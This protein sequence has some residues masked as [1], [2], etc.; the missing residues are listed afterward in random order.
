MRITEVTKEEIFKLLDTSEAGLKDEE[1]QRRLLY[2]G[3]N[4]IKEIRKTS[5]VLKFLRQFTHFLA[6]ILWLASALAFISDYIHPG[7]GMRHLGFAIIGVICINA[8]FAFVQEYKAEKAIEKLRQMLPFY[9]KVIRNGI[10]KEIPAREIVPGDLIIL[11]EGDKIPADARVIESNFLT[12][13]NAPLTGESIPIILTCEP[14][15]GE[16]IESNNIA[17]A[18]ATVVSGSGKAVVFA[19]GMTTEFGRIAHLT[20]TVQAEATPLQKEIAR[21]SKFIAIFATLIGLIFFFVG[22]AIGRSFWENFIF[23]IGVIVALVPEGMLPTVTLSLAI[24]SQRMLKRKALIKTLTSVEALGSITVICTDKTG[25]ITQNKMEVKKIWT[26]DTS[27][28]DMLMKIAYLCNNAKFSDNQYKGDPTEVA[29]LKYVKENFGG[30]VSER[31]SEIPFDFERK[32]MTTVNLIDGAKISLTKGAIETVLPLCKYAKINGKKVKLTEEIKEKIK[33]ASHSL[34]D[35]G[36]RVL[37]FAYSEDEPEKDMIFVGLIGLEDP[38]RPEVKEAIKKCHEAGV[39]I[40]LITG[41]ASRTALAIAKEIGLVRENPMII[42]GEEFHK[43]SDI[44]LKERLSHKEVIFTRMTPKDKLRIVTLLQEMGE[45]VAVTGDGVNDAPALK[46]A[47]IGIAM[48][49]GTDVAKESAEIILLDDNFATIVNA[50]EEGRAIYENIR[51]FISYFFTSNVAELLPC[52]AYAIFRIPLP[53]TVMQILSIDLGT[54]IFPALALGAE[55]PTKEVMK[56]QP[57]SHKERLLN[58]KLLLRV[59]LFLGPIEASAGL[60]GFF[61]VL[62]TGGWQWGSALSAKSILYMQATTACLTGIVLAQVANGFASRSF[63]ESIFS[64]GIFSNKFLL[65]GIL[66]E[67]ALQIFIVYHPVGNKIFSTYPIPLTVWFILIP[68]AIALI[69][70]EEIRKLIVSKLLK[71]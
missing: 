63:T 65:V 5:F 64:I 8:I 50:I 58:L 46:K 25:T 39:K 19:T 7:E 26:I 55:K 6:I 31:I 17:F 3:Y 40:I 44:E 35:E 56:K 21:T 28:V 1:A 71:V 32:R 60:F 59:F 45:R 12:V 61:Y 42:E 22:H 23:A 13:N 20:E 36:L 37:C 33:Y 51:K 57:R 30:F 43:L 29:L 49:S 67:I 41:D 48:G 53:L 68:F 9:V 18:G 66:F 54:D 52:I 62:Y 70:I 11:S 15:K 69:V 16:I 27:S 38:P 2:F 34:M 47:D 10:Q 14:F 24:G 4:E